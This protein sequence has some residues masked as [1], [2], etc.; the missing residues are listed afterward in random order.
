[1]LDVV[2]LFAEAIKRIHTGGSISS[3]IDLLEV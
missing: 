3:I 2:P 1:V